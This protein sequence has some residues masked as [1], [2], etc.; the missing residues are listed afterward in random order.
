MGWVGWG[1]WGGLALF[2]DGGHLPVLT[3][4]EA[5]ALAR[6]GVLLDARAGERYR[7]ETEHVDPVAGHIPGAVSAPTAANVNPDGTFRT[8]ADRAA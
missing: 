1:G 2:R 3:A 4:D 8:P 5:A 6:D 7:G